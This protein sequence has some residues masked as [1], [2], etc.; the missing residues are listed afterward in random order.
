MRVEI[1]ETLLLIGTGPAA[2]TCSPSEVEMDQLILGFS[3]QVS[4]LLIPHR[5]STISAPS[6]PSV[7]VTSTRSRSM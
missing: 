6:G 4:R 5:S 7:Q 1:A 2:A 3:G